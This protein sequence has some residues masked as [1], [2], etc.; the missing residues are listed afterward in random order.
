MILCAADFLFSWSLRRRHY[1]NSCRR[2]YFYYYYA[3]RGGHDTDV[4]DPVRRELHE[5]K[6]RFTVPRYVN[7][8]LDSAM[9]S[10]FYRR[11]EA[12][13]EEVP[14]ESLA[15]FAIRQMRREFAA[16]LKGEFRRDHRK[17]MLDELFAP[18]VSAGEVASELADRISSGARRLESGIWREW[19]SISFVQRRR[20]D[21]PLEVKL[22]ELSCY[23]MPL[24]ALKTGRELW[25][26]EN[27]NRASGEDELVTLHKFHALNQHR[28]P[29]DAVR[30]FSIDRNTGE[31]AELGKD[32]NLSAAIRSIRSDADEMQGAVRPDGTLHE[33]DFPPACGRCGSC[34]FRTFCRRDQET[35]DIAASANF[36]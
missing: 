19:N 26:V 23:C 30:S 8:L 9:R 15:D 3:A 22:N 2:R 7:A 28:C 27:F 36:I 13:D 14:A 35:P 1:W 33:R 20:I 5:L 34:R 31:L 10:L 25:I 24:F 11:F 4:A 21:A 32:L 12:E 18:G 29:P 6:M 17:P 16:M